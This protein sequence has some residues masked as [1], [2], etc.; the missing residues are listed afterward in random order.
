MNYEQAMNIMEQA[1]QLAVKGCQSIGDMKA[2]LI[3]WDTIK[4]LI[5]TEEEKHDT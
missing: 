3:A 2:I 4:P 5:K 1:V